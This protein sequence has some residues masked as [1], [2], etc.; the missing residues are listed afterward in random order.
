MGILG[1]MIGPIVADAQVT[2]QAKGPSYP[3]SFIALISTVPSPAT[4]AISE[5]LIPAKMILATILT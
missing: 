2:A 5:P 4:S 3:A 1:G